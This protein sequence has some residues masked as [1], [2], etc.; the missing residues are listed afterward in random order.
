DATGDTAVADKRVWQGRRVLV[1][2]REPLDGYPAAAIDGDRRQQAR[3]H[4]LAIDQHATR[5][6]HADAATFFRSSQAQL[7][8]QQVD[9]T[10]MAGHRAMLSLPVHGKSNR[11]LER[12]LLFMLRGGF[13]RSREPGSSECY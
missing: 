3:R 12:H 11:M 10:A 6:A 9:Q 4:E 1:V 13:E 8:T 2:G 7:I 5:A